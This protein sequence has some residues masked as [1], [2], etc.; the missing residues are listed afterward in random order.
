M[1]VM[2]RCDIADYADPGF[3][4][5]RPRRNVATAIRNR[6]DRLMGRLAVIARPPSALADV[7]GNT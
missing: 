3:E 5:R 1:D 6:I 2:H 7:P 4:R